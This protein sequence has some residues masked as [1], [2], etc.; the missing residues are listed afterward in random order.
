MHH[1]KSLNGKTVV[2]TGGTSG[3][4]RAAAEAFALEGARVV[5]AARGQEALEETVSLLRDLGVTALGVPT[6]VSKPEDLEHLVEEAKQY[7]G[8]ID[9]W[10]NNAGVM[11]TG[12]IEDMPRE[13]LDR[14]IETNLSSVLHAAQI[15]LPLFKKQQEG[16]FMTNVSIGGHMPVPFGA[17]YSASKYGLRGLMNALESEVKQYPHIKLVSLYPGMQRSTGNAHSAKYSGFDLKIPPV[18]F[19]PRKLAAQMVKLSKNPKRHV[20][21]DY[22]SIMMKTLY[23]LAPSL[24]STAGSFMVRQLMNPKASETNGNLFAPSSEP[25]RIYGE[26]LLPV[27]SKKTKATVL[28]TGLL[29]LSYGIFTLGSKKK[30]K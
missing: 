21:T 30:K 5:V 25:H 23:E 1:T 7:N 8:R 18:S 12:K 29:L 28:A 27:A 20:Y 9:I 16:V 2:I 15:V 6:D 10:I 17:A 11:A 3:V 4:G 19:D 14:I 26:T 13:A 24:V 22:S